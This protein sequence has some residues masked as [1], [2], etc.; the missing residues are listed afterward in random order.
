[1]K[2]KE[3]EYEKEVQMLEVPQLELVSF[4]RAS[5]GMSI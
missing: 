3:Q 5:Q 2:D 4:Q 1:M